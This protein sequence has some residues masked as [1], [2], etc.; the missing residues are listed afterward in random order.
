MRDFWSRRKAAVE[1]EARAGEAVAEQA[2]RAEDEAALEARSDEELLAELGLPFP[3]EIDGG[4]MARRFLK[5]A[6]PQR[7]KSRA[8]RTLWRSNPVLANLDGLV[9][10]ADDYTDAATCV[11]NLQTS[12]VVGKG[13]QAHIDHLAEKA[14][15][16]AA[17]AV[18]PDEEEAEAEPDL[19]PDAAPEAEPAPAMTLAAPEEDGE[20]A[21]LP[22]ASR[23]MR[24]RFETS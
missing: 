22:P 2:R 12:Y 24:F 8:L 15:R 14:E 20:A 17:L 4:E 5:S 23:R 18:A 1:A 10:Y 7:L 11:P 9:D 16:A 3:E 6:L 21:P 19:A 13:L